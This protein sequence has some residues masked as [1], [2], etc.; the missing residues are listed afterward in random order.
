MY[1]KGDGMEVSSEN[2][3]VGGGKGLHGP[4]LPIY[5]Q[6]EFFDQNTM[7]EKFWDPQAWE[8][9]SKGVDE[10]I[11]G[12]GAELQAILHN[13]PQEIFLVRP[14]RGTWRIN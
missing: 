14:Y 8:A 6:E 3:D 9:W 5:P 7:E 2:E 11:D 4:N 12:L 10:A 13:F 1:V